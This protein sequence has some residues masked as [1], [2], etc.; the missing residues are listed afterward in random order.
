MSRAVTEVQILAVNFLLST[1]DDLLGQQ[2]EW[3]ANSA[4]QPHPPQATTTVEVHRD[5]NGYQILIDGGLVETQQNPQGV[6]RSLYGRIL[7]RALRALAANVVLH[8]GTGIVGGRR[9]VAIGESGSGKSTVMSRLLF[10]GEGV[11]G[12]EMVVVSPDHV[13]AF[14]RRFHLR[15]GG[16]ALLPE[17][18]ALV[19]NLPNLEKQPARRVWALDPNHAGFDWQITEGSVDVLVYLEANHGGQSR[20]QRCPKHLMASSHE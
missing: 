15:A 1:N 3:L 12:D 8:A 9:L 19:D 5:D 17:I 14:P 11:E 13:T 7:R 16:V 10:D 18:A 4:R 2:F 6:L 20:I